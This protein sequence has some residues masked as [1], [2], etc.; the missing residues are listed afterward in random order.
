MVRVRVL[1]RRQEIPAQGSG[2]AIVVDVLRATSS[3][4]TALAAGAAEVCPV[5]EIEEAHRMRSVDPDVLLAGERGC[6]IIEGFD[7]GN[8]PVGFFTPQMRGRRLVLA[9]TNGSR[10]LAAAARAGFAPVLAGALLNLQALVDAVRAAGPE[11]VTVVCAGTNGAFSADDA[12]VAGAIAEGLGAEE[13]DTALA[14]SAL[15]R[16]WEKDVVGLF[17]RS[18]AGRNLLEVGMRADVEFCAR[19]DAFA[20]VPR[21]EGGRLIR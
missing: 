11:E 5:A 3:I 7:L 2:W 18:R 19:Q 9:T 8:S 15:W 14:A 16:S 13:D 17:V 4:V 1:W 20:V 21:W 12:L 10:A 6:R